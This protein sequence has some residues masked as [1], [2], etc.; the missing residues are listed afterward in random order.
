MQAVQK[1]SV[2]EGTLKDISLLDLMQVLSL[3]RQF[4]SIEL[5]AADGTPVGAMLMKS[6]MLL[7]ARAPKGSGK[8]AF[9][10]LLADTRAEKFTVCRLV[11]QWHDLH[12]LG[13]LDNL[14]LE[15]ASMPVTPPSRPRPVAAPPPRPEAGPRPAPDR[16][17]PAAA[18]PAPTVD[19][20]R[21]SPGAAP[22]PGPTLAA[23]RPPVPRPRGRIV[24]L[25][26]PKGGVGKTTL[27]LN[28]GL[29]LAE[30]GVSVVLVDAD[31][32]GGLADSLTER[33]RQAPGVYDVL[34]GQRSTRSCF[35]R[36]RV[37]RLKILPAGRWPADEPR[38][39]WPVDADAW[40]RLLEEAARDFHVV[41]VDTAAGLHSVTT[42]VLRGCDEVVGVVQA[43]A[44]GVRSFPALVGFLQGCATE[45]R[46]RLSGVVVN[47]FQYEQ[48]VAHAVLHEALRDLPPDSM[49]Q[50]AVPRDAALM[51]AAA[52]GV[53][54][55]L[56]G[57]PTPALA[58]VFDSLAAELSLRLGLERPPT[59][60]IGSLVD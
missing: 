25:S 21:P 24:A 58:G 13:R 20:D 8:D 50:P 40:A 16:T 17:P 47:M 44:L 53:P 37:E 19:V 52:A 28:L 59:P 39:P 10:L 60:A 30:R 14:V 38:S 35:L 23:G 15:S 3:G 41:L 46:P 4:M 9:F 51:E 43:E 22:T 33:V 18:R 49:L 7:D 26:S 48:R 12:P 27:V 54:V 57:Q 55:K 32:Q 11:G 56:L 2:L 31:P 36:T 34:T 1:V 42:A 5:Q 6:G 29:A 45:G